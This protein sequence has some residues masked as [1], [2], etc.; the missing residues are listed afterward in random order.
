VS[1]IRNCT[2]ANGLLPFIDISMQDC[3]RDLDSVMPILQ[4]AIESIDSL[5]KSD[6][7]EIRFEEYCS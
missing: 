2:L 7:A 5:D 1:L 4:A 3:Q 6:I